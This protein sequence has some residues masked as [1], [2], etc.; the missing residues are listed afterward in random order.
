MSAKKPGPTAVIPRPIERPADS[1]RA[2][3][4]LE[5]RLAERTAELERRESELSVIHSIQQGMGAALGFQN[6]IDLVGDKLR[7]VFDTG[8]VDIHWI[9]G[10]EGLI[11][12]L[13]TYQHGKRLN[14]PS[15]ARDLEAPAD[16]RLRAQQPLVLNTVAEAIEWGMTAA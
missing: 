13:Y 12:R 3:Q 14:L 7:E 2:L 1:A 9:D 5:R 10:D 15:F 6:I 8:D 16:K 11:H 4:D